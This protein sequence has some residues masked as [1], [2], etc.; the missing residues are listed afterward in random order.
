M[1]IAA[2]Y[3]IFTVISHTSSLVRCMLLSSVCKLVTEQGAEWF[4]QIAV[5]ISVVDVEPGEDGLVEQTAD[6]L[7]A[8]NVGC[9]DVRTVAVHG[10]VESGG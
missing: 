9:P 4:G 8:D 7:A 5:D 1:A 10:V 2:G 6:L 3:A